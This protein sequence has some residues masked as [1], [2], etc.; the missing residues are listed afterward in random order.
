[1][2][3]FPYIER[4]LREEIAEAQA[5]A[6]IPFVVLD[7]AIM[8][9]AGWNNVCDWIVYSDVP[10]EIRIQR[11]QQQRGWSE[12]EVTAREAAQINLTDKKAR[13]DFVIDNA[14]TPENTS[15]Q[16]NRLVQQLVPGAARGSD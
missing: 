6:R 7:A 12:K 13:A 11:L 1:M 16:V 4:R 5:E 14:G 15:R 3:V 2:L 9:E 8:L 10:R